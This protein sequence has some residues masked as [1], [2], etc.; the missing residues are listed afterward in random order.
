M[1]AIEEINAAIV[2]L[3]ELSA[4][5]QP[6]FFTGWDDENF[7]D[8]NWD[9]H[10]SEGFEYGVAW[11]EW[12]AVHRTID[13]QLAIMQTTVEEEHAEWLT[14]LEWQNAL[15]LARAINGDSK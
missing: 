11:G 10:V 5:P 4:Q 1:S 2:K 6:P 14:E 12:K 3:N 9:D 13:A 8:G 15:N 7:T